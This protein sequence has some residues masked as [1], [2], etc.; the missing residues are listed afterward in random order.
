M[1]A[2]SKAATKSG[3]AL[4]RAR[5]SAERTAGVPLLTEATLSV[6]LMREP[7]VGYLD[8]D[9]AAG[10]GQLSR[11]PAGRV[12]INGREVLAS[13]TQL[14]GATWG[15]VHRTVLIAMTVKYLDDGGRSG[16]AGGSVS[17]LARLI[18]GRG[19]GGDAYRKIAHA[20]HDLYA[21][22][23]TIEGFDTVTGQAAPGMYS[24]TRLLIDLSWHK[25]LERV[26]KGTLRG[27]SDIGRRLGGARGAD[28]FR[29]RFHP[30]YAERLRSAEVVSLDWER[31][32]GLR[33]VAQSLWI[34]LSAPRFEF[35]AVLERPEF[36]RLELLLDEQTY[37]AF[38][39]HACQ[40]RDRRRTLNQA[41]ERIT[42]IDPS[43]ETFEAHGGRGSPSRLLVLRRT[44]AGSRRD[45]SLPSQLSLAAS[46]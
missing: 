39:I 32:R 34:Q 43:Y 26:F 36:E 8:P 30:T 40:D 38:G 20:I 17:S 16:V 29:W 2:R 7:R 19:A 1:T 28:T 4:A 3:R 21:G 44:G 18:Y 22:E 10:V 9:V 5:Q 15:E 33:G 14:V 12:R 23:L 24:R 42:A 41:G 45:P 35:R 27:R 6:R 11:G 31:L 13:T 46:A 37:Q 25:E